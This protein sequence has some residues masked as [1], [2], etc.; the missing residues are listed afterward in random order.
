MPKV[1]RRPTLNELF[2]PPGFGC[3]A[4]GNPD[5]G[6]EKSWELNAGVEQDLFQDRVKLGGNLLS[7]R[8]KRFDRGQTQTQDPLS[9]VF[10]PKMSAARASTGSR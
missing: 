7:P 8:S 9:V 5:L 3:P 1:S 4:F 10:A 6:P 2:F